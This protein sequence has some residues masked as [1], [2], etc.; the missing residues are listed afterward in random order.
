MRLEICFRILP[1]GMKPGAPHFPDARSGSAQRGL[2]NNLLKRIDK[3][4]TLW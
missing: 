3:E 4:R 2:K 1:L